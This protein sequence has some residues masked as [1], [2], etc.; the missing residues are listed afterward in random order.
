MLLDRLAYSYWFTDVLKCT[1]VKTFSIYFDKKRKFVDDKTLALLEHLNN[2]SCE[3]FNVQ[4]HL[5]SGNT[6]LKC[7][8]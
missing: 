3:Y 1:R 4:L 5:L 8:L 2:I 7:I 6:L